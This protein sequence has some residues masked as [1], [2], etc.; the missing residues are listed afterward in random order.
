[1]QLNCHS[2][3][4]TEAT[5]ILRRITLFLLYGITGRPIQTILLLRFFIHASELLQD[6]QRA[7]LP[8]KDMRFWVGP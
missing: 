6:F 4:Y 8:I 2:L 7:L 1:M 5:E 3:W